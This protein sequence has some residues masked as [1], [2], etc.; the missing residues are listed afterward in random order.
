MKISIVT[1]SFNQSRYL[2]QCLTSIHSQDHP[3]LEH[4]VVDPGST[5][6]SREMV[7]EYG[8]RILKVFEPDR[9]AAD[10][11]NKGFSHA[12]GE[13]LGYI[14]SDDELMPSALSNVSAFFDAHPDIDV[15]MGCGFLVDENGKRLRKLVSSKMSL[16][17]FT[18]GAVAVFQQ[19]AFF[20]RAIFDKAGGF[21]ID[22]RTC[23]DGELYADMALAGA[24]FKAI[25]TTLALFRLHGES[26]TGSGRLA[27]QFRRDG[28][29]IV[30]KITQRPF[31]P[32][33]RV[34]SVVGRKIKFF[35]NPSYL[36]QRFLQR[37]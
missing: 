8:D 32:W 26:I 1:I 35:V 31:S 10:G 19:G 9:G 14:N 30:E 23:W 18:W 7:S 16:P 22:N 25:P 28:Q 21:N 37:F 5:D 2:R 20:R 36:F 27:E 29:R 4:I 6:G 3:D 33:D 15:V 13:I 12:T 34:R 24:R 11:L 17:L